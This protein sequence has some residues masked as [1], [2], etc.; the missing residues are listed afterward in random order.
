MKNKPDIISRET[1]FNRYIIEPTKVDFEA[2][3]NLDA[4]E[5]RKASILDK[6]LKTN[7]QN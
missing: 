5:N 7:S 2:N 4:T 1:V 6:R 3:T